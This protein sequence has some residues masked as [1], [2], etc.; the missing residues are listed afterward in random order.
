MNGLLLLKRETQA[1]HGTGSNSQ[2]CVR[3]AW[4]LRCC[5]TC[6]GLAIAGLV[7]HEPPVA[8]APADPHGRQRCKVDSALLLVP[9]LLPCP[10]NPTRLQA[11]QLVVAGQR[12]A[13]AH[14]REWAQAR[15]TRLPE[16]GKRGKST[17]TD[18]GT[19]K[20]RRQRSESVVNI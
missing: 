9:S 17:H 3:C 2:T 14:A 4:R 1:D 8:P 19:A 13:S 11:R 10:S 12:P 18:T 6:R 20:R 7:G 16:E 5:R 15:D